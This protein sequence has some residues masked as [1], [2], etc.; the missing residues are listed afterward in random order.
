M[1]RERERERERE[2]GAR[3]GQQKESRDADGR[4]EDDDSGDHPTSAVFFVWAAE[5]ILFFRV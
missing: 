1:E 3:H 2:K 5:A 4:R